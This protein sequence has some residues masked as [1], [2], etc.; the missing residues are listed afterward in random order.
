MGCLC[1]DPLSTKYLADVDWDLPNSDE[2]HITF[3]WQHTSSFHLT[4]SAFKSQGCS[5]DKSRVRAMSVRLPWSISIFTVGQENATILQHS[6]N[7]YVHRGIHQRHHLV[8]YPH[9]ISAIP[10][11]RLWIMPIIPPNKLPRRVQLTAFT[12]LLLSS[13]LLFPLILCSQHV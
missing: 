8:E 6:V 3:A 9:T 2:S 1:P 11:G 12:M 7:D 5:C 13:I 4:D 10:D